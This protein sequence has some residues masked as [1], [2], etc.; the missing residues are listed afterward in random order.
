MLA[1]LA[2]FLGPNWLGVALLIWAPLVGLARMLLGVH[3]L[4]DILAGMALGLVMG[5]AVIQLF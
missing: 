1:V 5:L 3:Y 4:S 2:Q